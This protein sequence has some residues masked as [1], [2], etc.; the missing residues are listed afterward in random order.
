MGWEDSLDKE[1]ATL[2]SILTWEIPWTE[3]LADYS[4]WGRKELDTNE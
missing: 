2:S 4:S 1:M 3:S